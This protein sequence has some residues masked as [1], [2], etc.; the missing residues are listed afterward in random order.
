MSKRILPRISAALLASA[1]PSA[2]IGH[3][4]NDVQNVEDLLKQV[5]NEL[6]R[7]GDDLKRTA[8]N[9]LSEAKNA[10][11]LSSEVKGKAD[12]LLSKHNALS[13]AQNKLND[14]LE[15]VKAQHKELEQH[16]ADRLSSMGKREAPKSLGE[17][18]VEN[19]KL[20]DYVKNGAQGKVL[21][22]VNAAITSLSTSAGGLVAPDREA[23]IVGMQRRRMTVRDLL[24][25]GETESNLVQY[26]KQ[27]TRTNNAAAVTEGA[28]KPTSDYVWT[29]TDAPVR[30][31]AHIVPIS[32]QALDDAKQL[33]TEVDTEMRYGLDFAE[34][35]QL[36]NGSGQGQNLSGLIINATAYSAAFAPSAAQMIDQLRLAHLQASLAEF[37][38]DGQILNPTDWARIELLKDGENRY[39]WA[40]PR[41]L[42]TP[43]LW[44]KPVV[45]TA[46]MTVDKFLVGAFKAAAT[47]YDRMETEVLISSEDGDNFK[48][49]MYTMR[50]EKRL[51][52]AVK[53]GLALVYGDFGNVG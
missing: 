24:S 11:Q 18:V 3:V 10:G 22:S 39:L 13:D 52:L 1:I 45:E 32:R 42:G 38:S 29:L 37:V 47:I 41:G 34:E 19:Q 15:G 50:A 5:N 33:R 35:L 27:T 30:T 53:R 8:E 16:V 40:N 36:L 44:G 48:K 12:E 17:L 49:N 4:R 43:T 9:A 26:P 23:E 31:I 46:A 25:Q 14:A 51:A 21:I 2:V 20:A 7:V 28:T 6:K